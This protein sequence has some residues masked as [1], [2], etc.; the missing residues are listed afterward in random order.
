F[1][2]DPPRT[3]PLELRF[4]ARANEKEATLF[5]RQSDVKLE[6]G[7][8]LN[9]KRIGKLFLMEEELTTPISIP[10]GGLRD[11]ENA[12]TLIQP[13]EGADDVVLREITLD[14]RPMREAIHQ[15][16]LEVRV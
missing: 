7:V 9:G 15:A 8:H 12:L 11:G 16:S 2:K 5:I 3:G 6:W 10:A 4:L 13:I 14:P 1:E